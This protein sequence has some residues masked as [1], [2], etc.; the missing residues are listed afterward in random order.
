MTE[1]C[2]RGSKE[3]SSAGLRDVYPPPSQDALLDTADSTTRIIPPD[4]GS[5]HCLPWPRESAE[6]HLKWD[7]LSL[8]W[9]LVALRPFQSLGDFKLGA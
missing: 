1:R 9:E 2:A 4:Y 3:A 5:S 6:R 7:V 8:S